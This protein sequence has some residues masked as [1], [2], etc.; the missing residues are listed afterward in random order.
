MA[1]FRATVRSINRRDYSQAQVEAWAPDSLDRAA[2]AARLARNETWVALLADEVA[3]FAE[4]EEGGRLHAL[5][6]HKDHQRRGVARALLAK[7]EASARGRKLP[8]LTTE[9][10]I[11]ARPCFEAAGFM[12]EVEQKVELRGQ[13]F[14]NYRMRRHLG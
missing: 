7:A 5:F 12:V 2:W 14:V 6:V 10:S 11:T 13:T 4:L 3:G 1:L 8:A 9:A